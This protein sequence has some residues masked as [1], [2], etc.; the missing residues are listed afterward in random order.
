[1]SRVPKLVATLALLAG[2][3]VSTSTSAAVVFY[4]TPF[5]ITD[6]VGGPVG[7][8]FSGTLSASQLLDLPR[9]DPTFGT[10]QGVELQFQS[11]YEV[12]ILGEAVDTRGEF[13]FFPFGDYNDAGIDAS[14]EG[15][16]RIQL[17]EPSSIATTLNIPLV[18]AFCYESIEEATLVS[19]LAQPPAAATAYNAVMPLGALGLL[20][21]VGT[22]PINPLTLLN[23]TF[24]G[25]CDGDDLADECAL[26]VRINWFGL[27]GVTYTFEAVIAPGDPGGGNAV[28]EPATLAMLGLGLAGLGLLRRRYAA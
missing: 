1:M 18:N 9:F 3:V 22:D 7:T 14:V 24:S 16:L 23:A 12:F 25:T 5:S 17:F 8:N 28:P 11:S 15:F 26:G 6:V 4:S 21:F 20:D 19:C 10:L 2:L 27:V 13:D